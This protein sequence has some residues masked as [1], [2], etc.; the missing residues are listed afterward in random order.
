[1]CAFV[2]GGEILAALVG[3]LLLFFI[4]GPVHAQSP[5][6]LY[7][8][9]AERISVKPFSLTERSGVAI[10]NADLKGKV[11][12]AQFFF[13]TCKQ[14]CGQT[15]QTMAKLQEVF[16]GKADIAL[17]SVDLNPENDTPEVLRAYADDHGADAK[18]WLFVT[19]PAE[20][21]H[22][23]VQ[24]TFFVTAQRDSAN[25]ENP[26]QHDFKLLLIDRDGNIRGYVDGRDPDAIDPLVRRV[27]A[28]AAERYRLPM[29][30]ALLNTLCA[31]LLI[32]GYFAIRRGLETFHMACM[33]T[34][35]LVSIIFLACY[36]Y[37]HFAVLDGQ[38]TRFRGE[39]WIRPIYYTILITHTILATVTA[40]LALVVAI[41]GLADARRAHRPLARCTLPIW[42]YVSITGVVVYWLLYQVYP[43][44]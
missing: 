17:V 41:L 44:Y 13:A 5:T 35:L 1:V 12:I 3:A 21:I 42:L 27:R 28:L 33:L 20:Q 14:G 15:T 32:T 2:R 10:T 31:G 40:P 6:P 39:G 19:G 25:K 23:T 22:D 34:A 37:F 7:H 16:R 11:W 24:N 43:P 38:P 36:L 8:E 4:V 9:F 26:I 18:Q 29:L 30:N